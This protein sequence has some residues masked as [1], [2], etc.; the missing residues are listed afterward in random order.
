MTN[1]DA[2]FTATITPGFTIRLL[3]KAI[4]LAGD[5]IV[6]VNSNDQ[7]VWV[8]K[9]FEIC[10]GIQSA[11]ILGLSAPSIFYCASGRA[12]YALL[13]TSAM[14]ANDIWT[15]RIA[16][17]R[18]DGSEYGA[19]EIITVLRDPDGQVSHYVS[20]LHD[21]TGANHAIHLERLRA[22]Q[23]PVTGLA[24]RT[25]VLE[26]LDAG[27]HEAA[28]TQGLMALIF[29]DLDGFK[30]IND[31]HGHLAGD[32]LLRAVG[33]RLQGAVRS[34][35]TV[36][37]FGGDEFVI[38][39]P[40]LEHRS[41]AKE[42]AR[43]LVEQLMQ[44]FAM[45]SGFHRIGASV[46]MAFYPDHGADPKTLIARAD[47]AMYCAK[48]QGGSQLAISTPPVFSGRRACALRDLPALLS[49]GAV[50][51]G[52]QGASAGFSIK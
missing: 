46:G 38:V 23:D 4:E 41:I 50:L 29:I 42:I 28:G 37:R 18:A 20:V 13:S 35:D 1:D 43:K 36:G 39:L 31:T 27:L 17:E 34:S 14:A 12:S 2:N 19:E 5:P 24:N 32:A 3:Q 44:P 8:N 48:R 33:S 52:P 10:S 47:T 45:E 40:F 9:A 16:I 25:K 6:I 26:A 49:G 15:R 21:Q 51:P 22:N 30:Q 11:D 7:I